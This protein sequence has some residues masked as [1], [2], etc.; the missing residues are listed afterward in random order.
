MFRSILVYRNNDIS[1]TASSVSFGFYAFFFEGHI[2]SDVI[3]Q[4]DNIHGN[5]N[6]F[7]LGGI[8]L[9]VPRLATAN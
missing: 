5:G 2:S 4:S 8:D 1:Q 3:S 7:G 9:Q 6:V